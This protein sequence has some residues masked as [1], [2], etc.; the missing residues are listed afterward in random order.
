MDEKHIAGF[1]LMLPLTIALSM[2][3]GFANEVSL[4]HLA[5]AYGGPAMKQ[6]GELISITVLNLPH[7]QTLFQS[8]TAGA[9]QSAQDIDAQAL[10]T[11]T[12]YPDSIVVS[13][14]FSSACYVEQSIPSTLYL[15]IK[16]QDSPEDGM[17]ANI[18]CGRDNAGRGA[19]L[20][21]LNGLQGWPE[22]WIEGL[23]RPPH[24]VML[25]S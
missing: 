6:W 4:Q 18:M 9:S 2:N 24:I 19:V 1:S 10:Q 3:S 11:L 15:A 7:G 8:I 23:F 20:G 21:A 5:L 12:D 17:I 25:E 16:Y 13:K 22:R 14:H